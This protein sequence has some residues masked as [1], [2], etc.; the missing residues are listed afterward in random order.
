MAIDKW[1][2]SLE[3][4][5]NLYEEGLCTKLDAVSIMFDYFDFQNNESLWEKIPEWGQIS[6]IKS[7]R[8]F[9][10]N[11]EFIIIKGNEIEKE[12]LRKQKLLVKK[13]LKEMG[14]I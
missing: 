2:S 5:I 6:I 4:L 12:A 1:A 14:V 9:D 3:K 13:S 10:E 7:V 11:T 8:N